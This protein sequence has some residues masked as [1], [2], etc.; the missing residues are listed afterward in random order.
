MLTPRLDYTYRS[1]I[2]FRTDR[3]DP[4]S[5]QN[6]YGLANARLTWIPRDS[7]WMVAAYV[8]NLT[9]KLYYTTKQD[10]LN[11]YGAA[12]GT[13]APPREWGVTV[14]RSF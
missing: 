8:T 13:V 5:T 10:Q 6:A 7:N 12:T 1:T 14:R 4:Y 3:T 9:N 11:Q 2:Y